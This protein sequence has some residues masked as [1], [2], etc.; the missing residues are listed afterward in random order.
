LS[1]PLSKNWR[2]IIAPGIAASLTFCLLILL[3]AWQLQRLKWKEAILATIHTA[4][5]SAPI[6]LPANPSPY[7]KV[8]ISGSWVPGKAA[9]Y[10][11]EVHDSPNGPINGAE[12]IMPLRQDNGTMWLVDLGWVPQQTPRALYTGPTTATGYLHAPIKPGVFSG[13]DDPAAGLYYTLDP[14]RMAAGLGLSNVAPFTLIAMGPLPP[15]GSPQ[16]QPAQH[17]PTPPNNHYEYALEW[18][19]FAFV[20]VFQFFFFARQRLLE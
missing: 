11:Q 15:P 8:I 9:L 7:Q 4:E 17:L 20:L 3:G 13:T 5:I 1:E 14:A 6:P 12:L 19:G 2:R 18:F 10:G 16:P